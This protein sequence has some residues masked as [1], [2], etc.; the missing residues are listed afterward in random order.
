MSDLKHR[1]PEELR[2]LIKWCEEKRAEHD[3][4]RKLKGAKIEE[5]Q[6]E[7]SNHG[8]MINSIG[9]KE[10]SARTYL[11]EKTKPFFVKG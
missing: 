6:S 1:S 9:Q 2:S 4:S 5:L 3:E 11:A 10:L 7:I 8:K